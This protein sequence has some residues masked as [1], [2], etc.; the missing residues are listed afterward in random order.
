MSITEQVSR[1]TAHARASRSPSPSLGRRSSSF[2]SSDSGRSS[3]LL[4]KRLHSTPASI[5]KPSSPPPPGYKATPILS[6]DERNL[7]RLLNQEASSL[8]GSSKPHR[9]HA[10]SES[11][12][13]PTSRHLIDRGSPHHSR[14]R[15]PSIRSH[16]SSE[17][18]AKPSAADHTQDTPTSRHLID[19]GSPHHSR[20]RSPSIRQQASSELS[21]NTGLTTRRS[22]SLSVDHGS[23][24]RHRQSRSPST[25]HQTSSDSL[26]STSLHS[27]HSPSHSQ[28]QS[29]TDSTQTPLSDAR[30]RR[31]AEKRNDSNNNNNIIAGNFE[32]SIIQ[33]LSKT[34]LRKSASIASI[35]DALK[36][37]EKVKS[38][39]S[40][41][42]QS[43]GQ[44][45]DIR[46]IDVQVEGDKATPTTG[47]RKNSPKS[48]VKS[49]L[50]K[51][52]CELT[53]SLSLS[54][55]LSDSLTLSHL[56][57]THTHTHTH[58]THTHTHWCSS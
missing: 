33:S 46:D 7:Q 51:V 58:T 31:A 52:K 54:L 16:A 56:T 41:K 42:T 19:R 12:T 36:S 14:S 21:G 45:D 57:H 13:T 10:S 38:S 15:S 53:L 44:F 17:S 1:T 40:M 22:R 29:N 26:T 11:L 43:R 27:H 4:Q 30:Q 9:S 37:K 49:L 8:P 39:D 20:S 48:R 28:C 23:S 25:Y 35:A 24:P 55:S 5:L 47:K 34:N 32:E 6:S 18:L 50:K 3:Q 2:S